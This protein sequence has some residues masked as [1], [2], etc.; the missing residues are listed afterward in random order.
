MDCT[1]NVSALSLLPYAAFL[2]H[3]VTIRNVMCKARYQIQGLT[4]ARSTCISELHPQSDFTLNS[5]RKKTAQ[6]Q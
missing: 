6:S 2:G 4:D 1:S 3:F 5:E